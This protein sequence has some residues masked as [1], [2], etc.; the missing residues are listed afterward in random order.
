[1][2]LILGR[3]CDVEGSGAGPSRWLEKAM[4]AS[5]LNEDDGE[6][7]F[8]ID[9]SAI[10]TG[11]YHW[12]SAEISNVALSRHFGQARDSPTSFFHTSDQFRLYRGGID[13]RPMHVEQQ[14][15]SWL[16]LEFFASMSSLVDL[17]R[18]M[19]WRRILEFRQD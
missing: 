1:M 6:E 2:L 4:Q 12:V 19:G 3:S 15:L 7:V 16:Q 18:V 11:R 14:W 13:I 8:P 10:P 5:S 17:L 9:M